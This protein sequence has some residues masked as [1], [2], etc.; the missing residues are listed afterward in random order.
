MSLLDCL[1]RHIF[2]LHVYRSISLA[3]MRRYM[4][5]AYLFHQ[6]AKSFL[7]RVS[8]IADCTVR[9][10][11]VER[12]FSSAY[13]LRDWLVDNWMGY[14]HLQLQL[15]GIT[16]SSS[17]CIVAF[18]VHAFAELTDAGCIGMGIFSDQR[19]D[20]SPLQGLWMWEGSLFLTILIYNC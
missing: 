14:I 17:F 11:C 19:M 2:L 18:R 16:Y 4:Q 10:R 7:S 15:R 8:L 3:H 12:P 1:H 6:C 5:L 9:H 13:C 20:V